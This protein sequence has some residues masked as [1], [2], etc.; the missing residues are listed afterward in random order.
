[1]ISN[2]TIIGIVSVIIV[3]N[4]GYGIYTTPVNPSA[5]IAVNLLFGMAVAAILADRNHPNPLG[6]QSN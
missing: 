2:G 1:M 3:A 6:K 5:W 4:T